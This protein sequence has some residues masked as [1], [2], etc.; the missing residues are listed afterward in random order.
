MKF[1]VNV[2]NFGPGTGPLLLR[3]WVLAAEELGYHFVMLSDHVAITEDVQTHYPA[4]FYEPF[5]AL[6]WLAGITSKVELGTT[7][8]ILPYRHP[9]LTARVVANIDQ[10]CNGRFIFGVGAGWA[11]QEFEA[12]RVSFERRGAISDEYLTLIRECWSREAVSS[13]GGE[14]HTA[15]MPVRSPHPP[16]W[17]GGSSKSA[18]LRA[19][20]YGD[21]WHPIH[22]PLSWLRDEG[23]PRLQQLADAEGKRSPAFCPR[24]R[25]KITEKGLEDESRLPGEGTIDQI[26]DD[27]ESLASIGANYVL[28][29]TYRGD[30]QGRNESEKDWLMFTTLAG[31]STSST[32]RFV[33]VGLRF[34]RG[35][36]SSPHQTIQIRPV[37]P[38]LL[39]LRVQA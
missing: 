28:F 39:D 37:L 20:R 30:P 38:A 1:G 21:A 14:V 9:L 2:L 33:D 29:D 26:R 17:V 36:T 8:A 12:L 23:V 34:R 4:P 6:A 5:T 18:I 15:P 24:I 7:V 19:V 32:R 31:F 22:E 25:L 35:N 11:K 27:L 10:L 16:I 3:Q 13:D